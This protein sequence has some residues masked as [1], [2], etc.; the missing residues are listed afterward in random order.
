MRLVP[1]QKLRFLPNTSFR[2]PLALLA[3]WDV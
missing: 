1:D 3:E 2:G